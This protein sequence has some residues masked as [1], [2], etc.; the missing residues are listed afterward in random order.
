MDLIVD[1]PVDP[2]DVVLDSCVYAWVSGGGAL[3]AETDHA[4]QLPAV[5]VA[6][7][8]RTARVALTTERE[9]NGNDLV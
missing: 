2:V 3:E 6:Y 5:G 9:R 8:Q 7:H 1:V 4:H